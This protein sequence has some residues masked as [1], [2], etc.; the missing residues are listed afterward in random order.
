V[1]KF[2][3]LVV[4]QRSDGTL[5]CSRPCTECGKWLNIAKMIGFDLKVYHIDEDGSVT[6]HNGHCCRYK[7][8]ETVC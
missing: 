6:L 1:L 8:N 5:G 3:L 7:A 4:R 2:N